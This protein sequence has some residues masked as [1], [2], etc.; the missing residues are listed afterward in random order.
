MRGHWFFHQAA[1]VRPDI[2]EKLLRSM[3]RD[4][5]EGSRTIKERGGTVIAQDEQSSVV[6]GMP[7]A[8][9]EAGLADAVASLDAIAPLCVEGV[10]NRQ[11][12]PA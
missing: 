5:R 1:A 11:A 2:V 6:F 10:L 9:I 12:L 4:G 7:R 8:V 3:G